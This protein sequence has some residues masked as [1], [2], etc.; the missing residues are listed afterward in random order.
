MAYRVVISLVEMKQI[1][2]VFG[3]QKILESFDL[4]EQEDYLFVRKCDEI[5]LIVALNKMTSLYMS[6]RNKPCKTKKRSFYCIVID[7]SES[8][9]CLELEE[10]VLRYCKGEKT[11]AAKQIKL[12]ETAEELMEYSDDDLYNINSWGAD[13]SFREIITM[14]EEGELLKPE[15][16]RKYCLLYTSPSPRDA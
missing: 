4:L 7:L 3:K 15:L 1:L 5:K 10:L 9:I 6:N 12:E 16:Q 14:Y 13:L 8:R 2:E 11:M